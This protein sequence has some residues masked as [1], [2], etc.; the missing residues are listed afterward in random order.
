M[1]RSNKITMGFVLVIAYAFSNMAHFKL[2]KISNINKRI[3]TKKWV[4]SSFTSIE[5]NAHYILNT[6]MHFNTHVFHVWVCIETEN[7]C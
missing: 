2:F 3:M 5:K 1:I 6:K 4:T 7:I